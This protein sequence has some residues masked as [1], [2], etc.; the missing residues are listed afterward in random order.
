M[1]D[2]E[3]LRIDRSGILSFD[4][5]RHLLNLL[6]ECGPV[7]AQDRTLVPL[8]LSCRP[9]KCTALPEAVQRARHDVGLCL[10]IR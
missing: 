10:Q 1:L 5:C 3:T 2:R 8:L 9:S 4:R 7:L 6:R